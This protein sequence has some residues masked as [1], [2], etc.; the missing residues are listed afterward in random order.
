MNVGL[1]GLSAIGRVHDDCWRKSAGDRSA[2]AAT[3]SRGKVNDLPTGEANSFL[4]REDVRASSS[5]AAYAFCAS[6]AQVSFRVMIRLKT[7]LPG[8]LSFESRAK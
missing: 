4:Y 1:I 5:A 3:A 2:G 6:L 7:G 8:A